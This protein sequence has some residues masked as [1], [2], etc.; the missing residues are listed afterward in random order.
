MKILKRVLLV[1][2]GIIIVLMIIALFLPSDVHVERSIVMKAAPEAA[3]NQVN[4]LKNWENWDPWKEKDPKMVV[5]YSGPESGK[6]ASYSWTSD[7]HDVGKGKLTIDSSVAASL[8]NVSMDFKGRGKGKAGFTFV[9]ADSGTKVTWS[10]DSHMG[11]NL[12]GRY[13]GLFMDKMLGPDFEHGLAKMKTVAEASPMPASD[14]NAA[15][16]FK[17]EEGSVPDQNMLYISETCKASEIGPTLHKDYDMLDDYMK[18][19]KMQMNGAPFAIYNSYSPEKV[20]MEAAAPISGEGKSSG[21]ITAGKVKAGKV[22]MAKYTGPYS[23][24]GKVHAAIADYIK[25]NNK[26]MTGSPWETYVTDPMQTKDSTQYVTIVYYP[27][28]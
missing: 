24:T 15:T 4:T 23:G 26:K 28:E 1:L 2:L 21:K 9:K 7:N 13:A 20:E 19:N 27:V 5:T 3:F 14:M 18:K 16:G 10:M 8:V 11:W 17:I 6:G 22:V 12:P 25:K